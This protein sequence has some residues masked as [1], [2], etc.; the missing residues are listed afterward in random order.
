MKLCTVCGEPCLD[1]RCLEH[2]PVQP[3]KLSS[4]R[5]GYTTSWDKLSAR[6]RRIQPWC[7]DCGTEYDLTA[8]HSAEAWERKAAGR[9]ITLDLIDVVCRSCN[10]KRG[11]A[12]SLSDECGPDPRRTLRDPRGKADSLTVDSLHIEGLS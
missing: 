9:T 4:R 10:S 1:G 12:R 2:R 6:A 11:A 8:D 5:R 3:G 7:S